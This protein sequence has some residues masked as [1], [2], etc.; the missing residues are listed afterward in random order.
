MRLESRMN[1]KFLTL[2]ENAIWWVL[3]VTDD[4]KQSEGGERVEKWM[5]SVFVLVTFELIA[6]HSWFYVICSLWQVTCKTLYVVWWSWFWSWVSSAKGWWLTEWLA[7]MSE[8]GVVYKTNST[9][10]STVPCGTPNIKEEREKVELLK[11]T[12]WFLS[13]RY[14]RNH[15]GAVEWTSKIVSRRERRIWWFI[16]P[17]A[18][19]RF[20]KSRT[21]ILSSSIAVN[22]TWEVDLV[23]VSGAVGG[24]KRI[25]EVVFLETCKEVVKNDFFWGF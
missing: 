22:N 4:G 11:T 19:K 18:A 2:S 6:A 13:S 25:A 7:M 12:D 17:K 10:P 15:W 3:T 1:P 21:E 5:V 23:A 16:V 8:S 20:I 24:L 9:W 14:N